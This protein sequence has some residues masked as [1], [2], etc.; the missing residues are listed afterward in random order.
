M[1]EPWVLGAENWHKA[2]W[3]RAELWFWITTRQHWRRFHRTEQ[4][5]R[6]CKYC[7]TW[8]EVALQLLTITSSKRFKRTP[9]PKVSSPGRKLHTWKLFSSTS[10][11]QIC[12][13]GRYLIVRLLAAAKVAAGLN[14][15]WP[16]TQRF[17]TRYAWQ[18]IPSPIKD[19]PWV[20][21]IAR[22]L[23]IVSEMLR[24]LWCV[25]GKQNIPVHQFPIHQLFER[26]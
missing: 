18:L 26:F 21:W 13:L 16:K 1:E 6:T 23:H 25:T 2:S 12:G 3:C 4:A 5:L 9:H 22:C 17:L 10:R 8:R 20:C 15:A 24:S 14:I 7:L 19:K 11:T